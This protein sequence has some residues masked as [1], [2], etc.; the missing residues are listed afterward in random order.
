MNFEFAMCLIHNN[1]NNVYALNLRDE[2]II[3]SSKFRLLY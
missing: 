2:K 1:F 3:N